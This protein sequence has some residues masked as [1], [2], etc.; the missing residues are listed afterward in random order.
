[1]FELTFYSLISCIVQGYLYISLDEVSFSRA[2]SCQGVKVEVTKEHIILHSPKHWVSI[3]VPK[4]IGHVRLT[5]HFGAE[6]ALIDGKEYK[7]DYGLIGK[8]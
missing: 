8:S 7:V 3:T 2:D 5:Y 4:G 1:M 6:I